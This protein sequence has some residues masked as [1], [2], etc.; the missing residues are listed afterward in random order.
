MSQ[1]LLI[2]LFTFIDGLSQSVYGTLFNL[3]LRHSGVP[4]NVVGRITSFSLWGAA[5]FG[6]LFGF[7]ADRFDKKK[8]IILAQLLSIFFGIY[9]VLVNSIVQL[10]LTSFFFGGFSSA[11]AIILS[12]LLVLK[13]HKEDRAKF[14][15]LNFGVGMFTGVFGNILGG[16][17]GD[18]LNVKLILILSSLTRLIAIYPLM[19]VNVES[20]STF[21]RR[22]NILE[23]LSAFLPSKSKV[24]FYYLISVISVGFGAGLF[25][26][27]GNVIFYDLFKF[28][29]TL[30]GVILALAQFATSL[31]A[32]F[33]HKLG[34]RFGDMNILVFSYVFVPILIVFLSFVRE[35]IT[36]TSVYVLRFAVM[37]MVS[38][39]LSALVFSNVPKDKLAT[40]NG[41]SNFVNNLSRALSAELFAFLT[42]FSNGYTLIFVISSIFYF[43]N[44]Y[45]MIR[46]YKH[47]NA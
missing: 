21:D 36:F 20:V 10:N 28:S 32:V 22:I 23:F 27:F 25:V 44:A 16:V 31:G 11:S 3:M 6:L 5:I 30:I 13:T 37:N 19:R 38:P 1:P 9:R 41:V 47:L 14:F 42:G 33:S 26:T 40:V 15:G 35:P 12:T 34:K 43:I 45:V 46:M 2:T 4:T 18:V 7:I 8:L 17:L 24:V 39:L 29:A